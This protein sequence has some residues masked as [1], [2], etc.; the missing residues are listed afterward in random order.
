MIHTND[1]HLFSVSSQNVFKMRTLPLQGMFEGKSF[2]VD[3]RENTAK[4]S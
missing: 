3:M 4:D 1:S 2:I